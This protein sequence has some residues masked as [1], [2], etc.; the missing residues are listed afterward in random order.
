MLDLKYIREN[1]QEIKEALMK[2]NNETSIID[3]IISFDEERRKLLQQIETLRAQRNQNSKLVAKLKAQ[4]KNDEAEEIIIQGKEISEQ[5]KNLE[6]DL[7]NIEDNLNYK[8]LWVPNIPDSDVPVGKDENENLEVRRWGKPREF[9]FEPKAH[10]DLGTELNLLDFDRAAKLSGS[11]FTILKGDIA[12]LEL[13]LINFMIDLHTKDHGYTFILPPHLVT[14]ETITSSG[15]LPKFEDDLYKTSLDQMYLISTA[16][17][18]LAGLH[19][20]ETLEFNSLPLKYVAY[21]PCYRREAGSYG[22]DVRGMIRQHQFDKVE[23]FW[24][25]TPEESSQALEE[26][27]SH[28]EKV[29]QLLNLPYR[30]VALCTGDLGFAAAKTYDLEVW[31]PSYN[32]YKEISSCS[33]TKDFQG[34]RGNIRYRDRENK[35][36]F[37]HTLNGSGLA[38]GR[39]L[40]AIMENYQ[41]A[42]GKIEIPEKLIPYMGK[43]FIG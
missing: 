28:A 18:S 2:R 22:K 35:L 32:D 37:V 5:I 38:V 33:N 7:K 41:T 14:K 11:R 40:V 36:N 15:Q 4:K 42:N 6:S 25:T 30:V 43:E 13:A 23:L 19:R 9:D 8:L 27:T 24:Y 31:L 1:P 29:L 26:L 16:E 10:W 34:R 20:N 3:E 21:T 39:T 17:V 12:R